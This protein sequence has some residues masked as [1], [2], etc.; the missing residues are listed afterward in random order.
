[1]SVSPVADRLIGFQPPIA[2]D[3]AQLAQQV[4]QTPRVEPPPSIEEAKDPELDPKAPTPWD[5]PD[6]HDTSPQAPHWMQGIATHAGNDRPELKRR[7]QQRHE[8]GT[9]L[10]SDLA[11]QLMQGRLGAITGGA[12]RSLAEREQLTDEMHLHAAEFEESQRPAY[13]RGSK[14][15]GAVV[16]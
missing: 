6:G 8:G 7:G 12:H 10:P 4:Q 3:G 9:N 15:R 13:R 2:T 1:M 14:N 5:A 11:A 16:T